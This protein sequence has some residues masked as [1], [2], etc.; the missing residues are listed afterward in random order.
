MWKVLKYSS[1][2]DNKKTIL[3]DCALWIVVYS[4][5]L[6]IATFANEKLLKAK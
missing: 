6:K 4:E 5:S 2:E 3:R 1:I